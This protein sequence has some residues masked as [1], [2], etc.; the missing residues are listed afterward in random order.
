CTPGTREPEINLPLEW[1]HDPEAGR[2]CWINGMAGTGKTTIAYS[3]CSRLDETFEL[4]ASFFC[5]R[6]IPE[7]R[8]IKH[9]I[10][11]IAYQLARFSFPFRCA[12]DKILES[13][14]DVH[15]RALKI[16][17]QKLIS[18]PL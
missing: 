5:S 12:L 2:T 6:V 8:Q 13:D 1:A 15:A 16:Q 11:S 18:E 14:P 3:V 10:P 17:Y 9:I 7:C 4:G